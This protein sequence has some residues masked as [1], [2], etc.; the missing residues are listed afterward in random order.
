[1]I[2]KFTSDL[3]PVFV[4]MATY[5]GERYLSEQLES[6]L[7][8]TIKP[9]QI[10][11]SDDRSTD[12]TPDIL[13]E[14]SKSGLIKFSVNEN[15]QGVISNFKNAVSLID[16]SGYIALSDQDDIWVPEKLQ[17]LWERLSAID[18]G[19][20]PAMVYS[21]LTV[22][23]R[24]GRA[25]NPSFWNELGQ[26]GYRHCLQTLLYGNFVTGCTILMNKQMAELLKTTPLDVPMHDAW[27]ALIAFSF[28][29]VDVEPKP[30]VH[31]RKH[32]NNVAHNEG[33]RKPSRAQRWGRHIYSIISGD[34]EYLKPELRIAE[35]FYKLYRTKLDSDKQ[36]MFERFLALKG[37]SF[38]VKKL[39]FRNAFRDYWK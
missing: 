35:E 22:V 20:T 27:L 34:N 33:Y 36:E 16:G 17:V 26:D 1:M 9:A 23:D 18:D 14:Y 2:V 7:S 30:L 15:K 8:Q 5:N 11:V 24:N 10:V 12:K 3:V 13:K 4:A 31:Y 21:D 37:R 19:Q 38:L 29:R 32:E 28:G 25:L 6:I 39:A